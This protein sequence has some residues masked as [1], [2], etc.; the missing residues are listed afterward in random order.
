MARSA[1][2]KLDRP[3]P[4][5]TQ[6]PTSQVL[7]AA[8]LSEPPEASDKPA[9]AASEGFPVPLPDFSTYAVHVCQRSALFSDVLRWRANN[10]LEHEEAGMPP[11]KRPT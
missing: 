4:H 5:D 1:G 10:M 8:R 6:E 7:P 9:R 3:Q 2:V 11:G